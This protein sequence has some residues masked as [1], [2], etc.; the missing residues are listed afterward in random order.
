LLYKF[1]T[2][3]YKLYFQWLGGKGRRMQLFGTGVRRICAVVAASTAAEMGKQVRLG[4]KETRT[5]ELRLDWL[6]SDAERSRFL[7]WLKKNRPDD[8]TFLATCRRR[9]GGGEFAGDV[10]RELYWLIQ[11]REA[12]CQWC[13]LEIETLRKLPDESVREFAIPARVL[14]S[15][16]DFERTPK[17]LRSINP[18]AH[19]EVDGVKIA[20]NA[21]T[22]SDSIRLLRL[23]RGSKNFVAVPMGEV[24][25]PARIVALREGSALAY[26]PVA[27][28]TA[29]GQ[30][31]LSEL[32]HLY[33][34]HQLTRRSRVYG[35]IGDPIGHSLSPL[36]HNTGFAA[37]QVDAVYLPF[38]VHQLHDF[39]KAIPEWEIRGFS[40][41]LPHK[42]TILK[43]LKECEPL[44]ADIGAVNT[45]VVRSD[46]SLYGC[47]TDYVG[48]LRALQKKLRLAGSRV[49]I[50][51]AGGSAR[52]AAFALARAGAT[53][54]ICARREKPAKELARAVGGEVVP[55][56]ALRTETFDAILNSTPIGM[57]PHDGISPLA[58]G[59]LHCRIVMDLI[60]RPQK[61]QLLKIAA[62][63]GIDTVSGVDMF[64]AQGIAQWEIWMEK[65]APE[66]LM[67][68]AVLQALRAEE[69]SRLR[70]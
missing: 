39:L 2:A 41:T 16:H 35:V 62:K 60:Y 5:V 69:K 49:L 47:N 4:L 8:A 17:L 64:L 18:P 37:H 53:V 63:K 13:D 51:G 24:G 46:G 55:R 9:E 34:A 6:R 50:F 29:P 30:V 40:V 21:R 67:R 1:D 48:V 42:Q 7:S 38:L 65:R 25:L 59:E 56:R 44:A 11:A 26:A 10:S 15:A 66:A 12:G 70:R 20:A 57:H 14:L 45:V 43:H 23:A 32:K 28:A 58:P 52:A 36:L 31:S 33:R 22:I 61:T 3:Y 19:G 27:A 68:R 54:G